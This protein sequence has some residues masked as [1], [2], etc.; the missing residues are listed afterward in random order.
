MR[1]SSIARVPSQTS[2][3]VTRASASS[4]NPRARANGTGEAPEDGVNQLALVCLVLF[5][6]LAPRRAEVL[7]RAGLGDEDARAGAAERIDHHRTDAD[8]PDRS[9]Q[10]AGKREHSRRG[11]RQEVRTG[12]SDALDPRDHRFAR[13]EPPHRD[14][15]L[16]GRDR[17]TAGRVDLEQDCTDPRAAPRAAD[18]VDQII[19]ARCSADGAADLH[20]RDASAVGDAR[21]TLGHA[22]LI[23][24]TPAC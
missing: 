10:R 23:E 22:A 24:I 11:T 6:R 7:E 12:G 2:P 20:D 14:I 4:S 19:G 18:R 5:G 21:E 15:E 13:G 16:L 1:P 17:G 3:V 9:H 8:D